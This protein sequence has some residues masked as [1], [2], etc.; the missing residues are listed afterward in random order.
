M[1]ERSCR[2]P[3][4]TAEGRSTRPRGPATPCCAPRRKRVA[5][6]KHGSPALLDGRRLLLALGVLLEPVRERQLEEVVP[7]LG[8]LVRT[9][10]VLLE[11]RAGEIDRLRVTRRTRGPAEELVCRDLRAPEQERIAPD[12]SGRVRAKDVADVLDERHGHAFDPF[13]DGRAAAEMLE[14]ALQAL[15][16]QAARLAWRWS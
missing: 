1:F 12:L 5:R 4:S 14:P 3:T 9:L 13:A 6:G 8:N 15:D 16:L 11:V 7:V 10:A 2:A